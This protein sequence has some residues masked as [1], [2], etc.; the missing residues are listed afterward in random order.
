MAKTVTVPLGN[1]LLKL[2]DLANVG[3]CLGD[4]EV[5]DDLGLA[6]VMDSALIGG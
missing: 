6:L 1:G 2:L 5:M 4:A 3:G